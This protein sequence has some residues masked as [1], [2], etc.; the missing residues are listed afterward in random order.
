MGTSSVT[1]DTAE[2]LRFHQAARAVGQIWITPIRAMAK[3]PVYD[4]PGARLVYS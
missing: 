3:T 2:R 1:G 4:M